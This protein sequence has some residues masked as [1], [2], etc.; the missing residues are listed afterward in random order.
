MNKEFRVIQIKIG[1]LFNEIVYLEQCLFNS[2]IVN[3][4]AFYLPRPSG[5][6]KQKKSNS[7]GDIFDSK[8]M[9]KTRKDIAIFIR[10]IFGLLLYLIPLIA[11]QR[12]QRFVIKRRPCFSKV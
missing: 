5:R 12:I 8:M 2:T 11:I 3:S 9:T 6:G 4:K 7:F 10:I 1:N